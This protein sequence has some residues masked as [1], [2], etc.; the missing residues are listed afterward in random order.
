VVSL[1]WIIYVAVSLQ[2]APEAE[3]FALTWEP[4]TTLRIVD[5]TDE[6]LF[7]DLIEV[8]DIIVAVDGREVI[9]TEPVFST[10]KDTYEL[11]IQRGD[12]LFTV[13]VPLAL[14]S[15][16]V[17]SG[18]F[19]LIAF[20]TALWLSAAIMFLFARNQDGLR[21]G[22]VFLVLAVWLIGYRGALSGVPMAGLVG[23]SLSFVTGVAI[24]Y[25]GFLFDEKTVV[26]ADRI[27]KVALTIAVILG[28]VGMLEV[29]FLYPQSDSIQEIIGLS[30][31]QFGLRLAALGLLAHLLILAIRFFKTRQ[32]AFLHRQ[33]G[34]LLIFIGVG[35]IPIILMT[36]LPRTLFFGQPLAHNL[37]LT[38]LLL[39]PAGYIFVVNRAG[40]V[41]DR[42]I[43]NIITFS[44]LAFTIAVVYEIGINA[45]LTVVGTAENTLNFALILAVPL[46]LAV[47]R[48]KNPL[49]HHTENLVYGPQEIA[50]EKIEEFTLAV[51]T[52]PD[53]TT[54]QD[55]LAKM[56]QAMGIAQAF[57][58]LFHD[59]E[60]IL[61]LS[62]QSI[63]D[64]TYSL[65]RPELEGIAEKMSL[66]PGMRRTGIFRKVQWAGAVV[67]LTIREAK[68]GALVVSKPVDAPFVN[69]KQ[70]TLLSLVA[71]VIAVGYDRILLFERSLEM[72]ARL[73]QERD[74]E[75][76]AIAR[77]IHDEPMAMISTAANNIEIIHHSTQRDE[78]GMNQA[79][80]NLREACDKLRRI[81]H[82]L[83]PPVFGQRQGQEMALREVVNKFRQNFPKFRVQ[84]DIEENQA[85]SLCSD[86][87]A[88][89]YYIS[90]EALNNVAKHSGASNVWV[91]LSY[92]DGFAR[93]LIRDDGAGSPK[94]NMSVSEL[95]AHK[96]HGLIGMRERAKVANGRLFL[97]QAEPSGIM[98]TLEVPL[99]EES[100]SKASDDDR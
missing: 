34:I 25:L 48:F 11:T 72:S 51:A 26:R 17:G 58:A 6:S 9:R 18:D 31:A 54:L 29:I 79:I 23:H 94:L 80:A 3:S 91:N 96:H 33:L 59:H 50:E 81:C 86:S 22:A 97:K 47:M 99:I 82:G 8:G 63:S 40:Y 24:A 2:V 67:P 74:Q 44:I 21:T 28:A 56:T 13:T 66:R 35:T 55:V 20:V 19:S 100:L 49:L 71:G 4:D 53:M 10:V 92:M 90:Q 15:A 5:V 14:D 88:A 60:Q 83:R 1:V 73:L 84:T 98:L 87:V 76:Q 78:Q 95:W 32:A 65:T 41:L 70:L 89:I 37:S 52:H 38:F 7:Q 30:W 75:R 27:F 85:V 57:I 42:L 39:I 12:E 46:V 45:V 62:N 36:V 61:Y 64:S 16:Q 93:V 43:V 77:N 69:E 68:I